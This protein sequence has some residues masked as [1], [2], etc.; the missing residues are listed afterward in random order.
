LAPG[1]LEIECPQLGNLH[2][3]VVEFDH[4]KTGDSNLVG[5]ALATK[6]KN[7][8]TGTG[9]HKRFQISLNSGL[10]HHTIPPENIKN[11][12]NIGYFCWD[13]NVDYV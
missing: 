4:F 12:S 7:R 3:K 9:R 1:T 10:K 2:F 13:V 5:W 8:L 6:Q 11:I